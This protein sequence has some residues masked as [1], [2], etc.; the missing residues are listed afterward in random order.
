MPSGHVLIL[1][2]N[3]EDIRRPPGPPAGLDARG[4]GAA[5]I[6]DDGREEEWMPTTE[7]EED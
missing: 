5:S 6:F 3:A 4:F 7:P 2:G 1:G